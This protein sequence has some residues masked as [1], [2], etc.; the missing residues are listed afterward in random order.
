MRV[1]LPLSP[2]VAVRVT[3]DESCWLRLSDRECVA[4]SLPVDVRVG[5]RVVVR[6]TDVVGVAVR[7]GAALP[8]R[9]PVPLRLSV[10][11]V[12]AAAL[13]L[14][15]HV[16]DR[17]A[18]A[19]AGREVDGERDWERVSGAV[20]VVQ[21]RERVAVRDHVRVRAKEAVAEAVAVVA[22]P[23][24]LRDPV[25]LGET[26][27]V[28]VGLAVGVRVSD[29]VPLGRRDH[30]AVAVPEAV[31]CDEGDAVCDPVTVVVPVGRGDAEPVPDRD[32]VPELVAVPL[33][34][35]ARVPVGVCVPDSVTVAEALRVRSGDGESDREA[36]SSDAEN[37]RVGRSVADAEAVK[38]RVGG[39]LQEAV[40]LTV[41]DSEADGDAGAVSEALEVGVGEGVREAVLTEGEAVA[42]QVRLG[43]LRRL[44]LGLN[45]PVADAVR[46]GWYDSVA[47]EE[48]VRIWEEVAEADCEPDGVV[49]DTE[50]ER[51]FLGLR[52][53]LRL[54]V[55]VRDSDVEPR[56]DRDVDAVKVRESVVVARREQV[57]VT[58]N[59][60]DRD[61]VLERA[62]DGDGLVL[63]VGVRVAELWEPVAVE[64]WDRDA[65][66]GGVRVAVRLGVERLRVHVEVGE[67]DNEG[68]PN[69]LWDRVGLGREDE[70]AVPEAVGEGDC[71]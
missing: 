7:V 70:D 47:V 42:L 22:L 68:E 11:A 48:P 52:E 33:P 28:Q 4:E 26:L 19:V 62:Q 5:A 14:P 8:V 49:R 1:L 25:A 13:P 20:P 6:D 50:R 59:E 16:R 56:Q 36:L 40:G 34:G 66:R 24:A 39:R 37:V 46:V 12:V 30:V 51:D 31:P 35:R 53:G 67:Y 21:D 61:R 44:A 2:S 69:L 63:C 9:V 10:F 64:D 23:L 55:A 15:L 45:V 58:V 43:D 41:Q 18:L 3:D 60:G 38:L 29:A 54:R 32:A 71:E 27:V 65:V 17:D 57:C